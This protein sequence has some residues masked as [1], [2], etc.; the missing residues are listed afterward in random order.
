MVAGSAT[1]RVGWA[2]DSL[3]G[4]GKPVPARLRSDKGRRVEDN[5]G[6]YGCNPQSGSCQSCCGDESHIVKDMPALPERAL[7]PDF[8]LHDADGAEFVLRQALRDGPVL[9]TFFKTSCPTCQYALPF[10]DRLAARLDGGAAAVMVSQDTPLD[11]VRFNDEFG[12][13]TRQVFDP[14]DSNFE[15]SNAYGITN[16]PTVFLI[17]PDGRI[18]H[19]MVSWSKDDVEQIARKLSVEPP[20]EP[21]EA[22]LP[23][24]PG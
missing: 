9:L 3:A 13:R 19:S 11:S 2:L 22:V 7:A 18:A 17:E 15:V 8:A 20:F 4:R 24:R 23:F 6:M 12:L 5:G 1:V 21:G 16:V 14:E 10:L